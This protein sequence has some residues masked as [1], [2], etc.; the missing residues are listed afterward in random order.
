VTGDRVT[1]RTGERYVVKAG[2]EGVV[3]GFTATLETVE[4]AGG[5]FDA[6][7]FDNGV[8]LYVFGQAEE[9]EMRPVRIRG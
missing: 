6:L 2:A 3:V 9:F 5:D 7:V 8:R 1:V 4:F